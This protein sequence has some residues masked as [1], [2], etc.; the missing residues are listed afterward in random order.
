MAPT[1]YQFLRKLLLLNGIQNYEIEDNFI[2][3][4]KEKAQDIEI[5]FEGV[6]GIARVR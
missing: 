3:G 1:K 5:I 4:D 2:V 6:E